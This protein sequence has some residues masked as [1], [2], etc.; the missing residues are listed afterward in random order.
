MTRT[1]RALARALALAVALAGLQ[2]PA[3]TTA[4]AAAADPAAFRPGSIISDALFFDG[5]AMTAAD[6]QRFLELRRPTCTEGFVCLKDYVA[7][8]TAQ[9]AEPG[10]CA[11]YAASPG[12]SAATIVAK[13]GV[14]CGISQKALLV[15]L[16]KEQG[17][18]TAAAPAASRYRTA[19]GFGCPDT[20]PCDAQYYGF[21]NQV[22]RAARQFKRYAANPASY[23]YRAG[24]ANTILFH[25]SGA[26]CG[27]SSVFIENQAT[28][29]L[30]TY[31]PY[32]PNGSALANLYGTGDGCASYG[33]RNFWRD[34]TDW[35]GSTQVG[36]S[37][38]RTAGDP[39][40]YLVTLDRKHLVADV[41]TLDSLS[42]LGAVGYVAQSFLDSR[43]TGVGL[44]RFV[45]DRA[46]LVYLVDRGWAFQV[47]DCAQLATWGARCE[48]Y[49][50]M[51][52]TDTQMSGF[53]KA[54]PLAD[55][56][57]TPEG[58]RFVI[59]QG[60]RREAAD[61]ASVALATVPPTATIALREAALA[62]LPYGPPLVR[63]GLVVRNRATGADA[64]VDDGGTFAVAAGIAS[65]TSLGS[66]LGVRLL[67][68]QSHDQLAARSGTVA[69]VVRT[70]DGVALGLT[71]GAPVRLAADQLAQHAAGAPTVS[72]RVVAALGS[73][74][75]GLVFTRTPAAPEL[76]LASAR[77]RRPV[78]SMDT[79]SAVLGPL[80][81]HV[82]VVSAEVLAAVPAGPAVLTPGRVVKA[83][84]AP[85]LFLVDGLASKVFVPTFDVLE[86]LGVAGWS[87][88]PAADL[89]GYAAAT[90]PLGTALRCPDVRLVG[91]GGGVATA[92]VTAFDA[93]GVPATTLD[94]ATCA[95]LPR[96]GDVGAAPLWLRSTTSTDL[97]LAAGG[98]R[99]AVD[100]MSTVYGVTGESRLVVVQAAPAQVAALPS[101]APV[102]APG[103]LV[104]AQGAPEI[105]LV[106]GAARAVFLPSLAVSDA[107]GLSGWTEVPGAAL[108]PYVRVAAPLGSALSCGTARFVGSGGRLHR[109]PTAEVDASGVPR[110]VLFPGTCAALPSVPGTGPVFVRSY[111]ADTV[112]LASG[113]QRRTV[114]SMSRL[115]EL[116]QGRAP[117]IAVVAPTTLASVP[118]G[119]PA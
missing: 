80:P 68:P 7:P 78:A 76:F 59:E 52:L 95:R 29:G 97:A 67:D 71:P 21:F 105:Y 114:P 38:V 33:N 27:T 98:T 26:A 16:Q 91:V 70:P 99:R 40:V 103:R 36:S 47:R 115:Y 119:A 61:E 87:E 5:S 42:S 18:V 63:P 96:R 58:K 86:S 110:T 118:L 17:L 111:D 82:V 72:A 49:A 69:G 25:P 100:A 50:T 22:Y 102:L 117:V 94:A 32:Q 73:S 19:M 64:L 34:Y 51:Q 62:T 79:V 77:T 24:R 116:T 57:V 112:Y 55:A 74:T 113:G 65:S 107:L 53:V 43:P 108:A 23:S 2:L 75:A 1:V 109:L 81:L 48:D 15:T 56:V 66:A 30:Y 88:V 39:R 92:D 11:G 93:S 31:T 37:L 28:A 106:D 101:G 85:E 54:G 60:R 4:P 9:P 90:H 46:G 84:G 6:V 14:S 45:R 12:E 44:G 3:A 89:A 20:A 35:F 13:V 10:L 41:E 8:T 104:K 83:T